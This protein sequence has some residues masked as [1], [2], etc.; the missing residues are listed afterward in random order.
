[1]DK[2]KRFFECL[3]PV[4][5]CNLKCPYCYV[6]QENRRKMELAELPYSP[7]HIANALRIE[8]V[9]G[10][11]WI[12]ICGVGET[13]AQKEIIE[14]VF[15]LLK[16]GHYVNVTTNGTLTRQFEYM[17]TTCK[18]YISH[19]HFSFSFHY[20]E[21]KRLN[22]I[23]TFFLN[24]S[25]VRKAGASALFQM[26]L[27]DEYLP[28]IDEI[29]KLSFEKVGCLPQIALTRDESVNPFKI[30]TH[31]TSEEYYE[32]GSS[33]DSSLFDFTFRNFNVKRTEFCYAGD[34]SF[35]LN[36]QTGWLSK[37]YANIEGQNIFEDIN[38]PI[39]FLAIG[40]N[41]KN[42]Y[43]V[44]SSHFL[45]LGVIPE[46]NTPTYAQLR[47]RTESSMYTEEMFSF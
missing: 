17:L 27:C 41:C 33:F 21:L 6:I 22:L 38:K 45:S 1:M 37:C 10:I 36:L 14:I 28:Y 25:L 3:L 40:K 24:L 30:W 8:R 32:I 19:L 35:V 11:C 20:T 31:L 12:S 23:N 46:L 9:G 16:K 34:W 13:L 26:N 18:D 39:N 44:N 2:P 29:K 5:V 43:C 15:E 4:S 47:N 7:N 42:S